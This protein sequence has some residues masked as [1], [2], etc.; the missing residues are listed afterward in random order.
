MRDSLN[1]DPPYRGRFAPSP[2]GPLHQGS[3]IAALAS[4]LDAR[5]HNGL[6]LLRME[7]LDPPRE[8][9]GAA[10][11]ILAS[12]EAHGL[13][14]DGEVLWQSQRAQAYAAA[15]AALD[16]GHHLFRCDCTRQM[17]GPGGACCGHCRERQA[18]LAGPVATRISV[19]PGCHISFTDRVQGEQNIALGAELPDFVVKRKDGL[20]AYQL[21]V[22]VDDDWQG[23]THIVRGS[24]LLDS[25]PRQVF[26]QQLLDHT[27]PCYCH[28]PV[29]T[30]AGGNKF[31]K[32]NHAPP[33]EDSRAGSNLR[34]ALRFLRQPEPPGEI[35]EIADILAFA[36]DHWNV[37]TIPAVPSIAVTSA[38]RQP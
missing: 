31:S 17:L 32:Q 10:G 4:Y 16:S 24:D 37:Q 27:T 22:V 2:T 36:C 6:W 1:T 8:E 34:A 29:I 9:A 12:L 35:D 15:L 38:P 11:R 19:P 26:L 25:T 21:A 5:H 7:D 18:E 28:L 30:D 23:I 3:L 20:D 14:W 33:L 13:H